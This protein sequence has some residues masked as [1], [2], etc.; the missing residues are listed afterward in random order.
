MGYV[1]IAKGSSTAL[2]ELAFFKNDKIKP[3]ESFNFYST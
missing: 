2:N 3:E 1:I